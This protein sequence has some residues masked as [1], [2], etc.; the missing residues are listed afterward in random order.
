[1]SAGRLLE[2]KFLIFLGAGASID[3]EMPRLP[4]ATELSKNELHQAVIVNADEGVQ[5]KN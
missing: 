3:H 2:A 1:M 5:G 4:P